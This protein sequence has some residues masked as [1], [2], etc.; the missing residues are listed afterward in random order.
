MQGGSRGV[1]IRGVGD[2]G[3]EV[4]AKAL[5]CAGAFD[6][7]L[8][9]KGGRFG[10]WRSYIPLALERL[11]IHERAGDSVI[12]QIGLVLLQQTS[13][14]LRVFSFGNGVFDVGLLQAIKGYDDAVNLCKG[15]I[16]ILLRRC[17]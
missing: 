6:L 11:Q 2:G 14:Y 16:Q 3:R 13:A 15:I 4:D 7:A 5:S 17:F 1:R 8:S 10:S 9:E 12:A